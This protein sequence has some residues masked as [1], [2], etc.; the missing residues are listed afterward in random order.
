MAIINID[1]Q[2][3]VNVTL[4][5][6]TLFGDT[7]I[8]MDLMTVVSNTNILTVKN[9]NINM[10][11]PDRISQSSSSSQEYRVILAQFGNGYEQRQKDGINNSI[12]QWSVTWE[13]INT[14]ESNEIITAFDTAAGI[15]PF[16]WQPP[17]ANQV[18]KYKVER[19]DQSVLSGSLSTVS[20]TLKQVFDI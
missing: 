20:A 6:V 11:L 3:F 8:I 13:N 14:S 1:E 19:Y 9:I 15:E 4:N 12:Q 2:L 18:R 10:P 7:T 16:L 5:D 17:N